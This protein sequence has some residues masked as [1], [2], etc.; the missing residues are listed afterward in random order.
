M[1]H[2]RIITF[3]LLGILFIFN[4]Q[5]LM[6]DSNILYVG[7][8]TYLAPPDP[9]YDAAINQAAWGSSSAHLAVERYSTTGAKVT[10]KSYFTGTEQV[11]CD[12]YYF[13][14]DQRGAMHTNR[15]TAYYN[16]QCR[17]VN[18]TITP[19]SMQLKKGERKKITYSYSP[20]ISPKPTFYLSSGNTRVATVED[21]GTYGY[22]TAV[23]AGTTTITLSSNA[24]PD[25]CCTVTV[26][27]TSP[28]SISLPSVKSMTVGD[29]EQLTATVYPTDADYTLAWASDDESVATVSSSGM[30]TAR[31]DGYAT[32]T[33]TVAGTDLSDYCYIQVGKPTLTLS[34]SPSE[35]LLSKGDA[36]TLTASNDDAEIYYTLNGE[37]PNKNSTRYSSPISIEQN[38]TLKAVALHP[39]YN[40]SDVLVKTIEVTSLRPTEYYPGNNTT[41]VITDIL[42]CITFN[43]EIF[44]GPEFANISFT[45]DGNAV[46]GDI[47][48]M[49]NKVVAVPESTLDYGAKYTLS[50]PQNAIQNAQ[51]EINKPAVFSFNIVSETNNTYVHVQKGAI[52]KSDGRLYMWGSYFPESTTSEFGFTYPDPNMVQTYYPTLVYDNIL[53]YRESYNHYYLNTDKILYGWGVNFDAVGT[54]PAVWTKSA[55]Y[56]GDGTKTPQKTPVVIL[57]DVREICINSL[58]QA[59]IKTDDTLWGWGRHYD[60]Q[61]GNGKHDQE[62]QAYPVKVLDDVKSVALGDFITAAIR[63]D[64]SLWLCGGGTKRWGPTFNKIMSDVKSI[65][66]GKGHVLAV[67]QD[68][69]LWVMGQNY[70]G[71]LGDGTTDDNLFPVKLMDDVVSTDC[72]GGSSL[73]LKSDGTLWRWGY[74]WLSTSEDCENWLTPRKVL[75]N[76]KKAKGTDSECLALKED[77][78]LW[79][80]GYIFKKV[81]TNPKEMVQLMSDVVD[82][83][84]G[85]YYYALKTDGSLWGWSPYGG[86]GNGT[87]SAPKEP[88][89]IMEAET[90]VEPECVDIIVDPELSV[91]AQTVAMPVIQPAD[92]H[93]SSIEWT[94]SDHEVATV[95]ER[96]LISA[97]K[98]GSC[99]ISF[100]IMSGDS[101]LSCSRDIIVIPSHL[102]NINHL[103][104]YEET[105]IEIYN[106][107]GFRLK[108]N[109]NALPAGIYIV[110]T[111]AHSRKVII[112]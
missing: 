69:S 59:A 23:G 87:N 22:V 106:L 92:A 2:L 70:D 74:L 9:P 16:F 62:G 52:L 85:D 104:A 79:G 38:T 89:C 98:T 44:E 88:V 19:E 83:W 28:T 112:R 14:Y 29:R 46:A 54:A 51:G 99:T 48:I 56:L 90:P 35:S 15:A 11:K 82:F 68:N 105:D 3:L 65:S 101:A 86:I 110:K 61:I 13:W 31:K 32:I 63:N 36:I 91:G 103:P 78:S 7:Q 107:S 26:K 100:S 21:V 67:K 93:I 109:L 55:G 80:M 53:N 42:P 94:S 66:C 64:G 45:T 41:A 34:A 30:V 76:V 4:E 33:A 108:N 49:G 75:D 58:H 20:Q 5:L 27:A 71:Q 60:S 73:A 6:A 57:T 40:P 47:R 43:N 111:G 95:S 25:V 102:S 10:V 1:R 39:D 12:Y 24:G 84:M 18:A 81:S 8:Y 96:G 50:L 37:S 77:G 72:G 17:P 97:H